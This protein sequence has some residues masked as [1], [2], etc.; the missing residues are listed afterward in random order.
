MALGHAN[1][2]ANLQ[3]AINHAKTL[4]TAY[5]PKPA[6]L[7]IPAL[8]T[9]YTAGRT[10]LE[11]VD[12]KL[13]ASKLEID[14]RETLYETLDEPVRRSLAALKISGVTGEIYETA[15]AAAKKVTGDKKKKKETPATADAEP[16]PTRS[17]AQLG[18][19]NRAANFAAYVTLLESITAYDPNEADLKT[20]ALRQLSDDLFAA[21]Q[22]NSVA[23]SAL[24][25]TRTDRSK[26]LYTNPENV[27][28]SGQML[29][30][31]VKAA[32]GASSPEYRQISKLKF[33]KYE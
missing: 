17:T 18:Y 30:D 1:N 3:A 2:V 33:K 21:N 5:A 29:K 15:A 6:Y 31:Y 19:D 9:L 22:K 14:D 24:N 27:V 4:G 11:A 23:E 12:T 10:A 28:S 16:A 32:F 7:K 8:E 26:V 13:A 25:K 20:T